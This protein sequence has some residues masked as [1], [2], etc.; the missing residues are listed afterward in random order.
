MRDISDSNH[1]RVPPS[2]TIEQSCALNGPI[3][4]LSGSQEL[5]QIQA[6]NEV[7]QLKTSNLNP[8]PVQT[9]FL[10]GILL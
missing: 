5:A 9:T 2:S 10:L 6:K 7:R 8:N 1:S 3:F 4:V